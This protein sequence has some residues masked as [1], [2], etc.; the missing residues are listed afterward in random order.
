MDIYAVYT[1]QAGVEVVK[2]CNFKKNN[3]NSKPQFL[4][5]FKNL[6][7]KRILN[8]NLAETDEP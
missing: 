2:F 3:P 6:N 5:N 7:I 8:Q 4:L 1:L